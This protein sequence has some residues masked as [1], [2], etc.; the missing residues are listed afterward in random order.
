MKAYL[1]ITGALFGVVTISH[2][3]RIVTEN[4]RLATQ[5]FFLLVTL[6]TT[7]LCLWALRLLLS[8]RKAR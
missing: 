8:S 6:L 5:P 7:G 2:I 1:I 3:A 4:P